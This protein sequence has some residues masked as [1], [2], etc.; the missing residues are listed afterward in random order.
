MRN[1]WEVDNN[2]KDWRHL[3]DHQLLPKIIK[4]DP[5]QSFGKYI[6]Q[7]LYCINITELDSTF[8]NFLP[9]PYGISIVMISLRCEMWEQV[10]C[11]DQSSSILFM[12]RGINY[13]F[14]MVSP[15]AFQRDLVISITGN[16]SLP[17]WAKA[18]FSASI[19][20]RD[21]SVCSFDYHST[22]Q[23]KYLMT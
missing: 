16:N 1:Y 6:S 8:Y 11:Q 12:N 20:E 4:G 5:Y 23:S 18:K 22:D 21:V 14:N 15:T 10:I 3:S 7:L 9:K 17:L 2:I 19:L 13:F